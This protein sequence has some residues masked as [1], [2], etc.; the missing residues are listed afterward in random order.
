MCRKYRT[1]RPKK[2]RI[3]YEST[4]KAA[5]IR[6][7][8][9]ARKK[10]AA[11]VLGKPPANET[12]PTVQGT[13]RLRSAPRRREPRDTVVPNMGLVAG[14]EAPILRHCRRLANANAAD[15]QTKDLRL[16]RQRRGEALLAPQL[17][18]RGRIQNLPDQSIL[19]QSIDRREWAVKDG[20]V[21]P[22]SRSYAYS[23]A[24]ARQPSPASRL[25]G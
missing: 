4:D 21:R 24:H 10:K 2:S 23:C 19:S 12:Q 25:R 8:R 17:G 6:K 18:L 3:E 5:F 13:E 15:A 9:P 11:Q 22:Q 7:Y 20:R 16:A 1:N 14:R